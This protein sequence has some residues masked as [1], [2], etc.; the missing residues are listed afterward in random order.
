[1][2]YTTLWLSRL[3]RATVILIGIATLLNLVSRDVMKVAWLGSMLTTI[4]VVLALV[5]PS[6]T[7]ARLERRRR[8]LV[9]RALVLWFTFEIRVRTWW[10]SSRRSR[11]ARGETLQRRHGQVRP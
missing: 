7:L 6:A 11:H 1:M 5:T 10:H 8:H 4:S 3:A 9:V 2:D